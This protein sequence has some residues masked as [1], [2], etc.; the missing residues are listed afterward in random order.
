MIFY[1]LFVVN[2]MIYFLFFVYFY[3]DFLRIF[4][5]FSWIYFSYYYGYLGSIGIFMVD[6]DG[7][8]IFFYNIEVNWG[9]VWIDLRV[10]GVEKFEMRFDGCYFGYDDIFVL[11]VLELL[12]ND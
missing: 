11:V 10:N 7:I 12:F 4:I 2:K 3:F 9:L 8:Y 1:V 6:W 5:V